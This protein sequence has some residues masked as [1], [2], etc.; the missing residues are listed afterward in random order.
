MLGLFKKVTYPYNLRN[1]LN[2]VLLKSKLRYCTKTITYFG[3][4]I[5]SIIP[6]GVRQYASLET[7][8]Q[9]IKL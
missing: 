8:R 5:W 6:D 2:M 7:F 4:K 1:G 9:K 3:Q